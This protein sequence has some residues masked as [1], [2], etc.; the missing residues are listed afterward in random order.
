VN[1]PVVFV[2]GPGDEGFVELVEGFDLGCLDLGD[3]AGFYLPVE[4]FYLSML[5]A[6]LNYVHLIRAKRGNAS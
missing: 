3:E 4:R 6:A 1:L 5:C 2:V